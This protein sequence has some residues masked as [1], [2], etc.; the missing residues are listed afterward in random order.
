MMLFT[1][2]SISKFAVFTTAALALT[3]ALHAQSAVLMAANDSIP[4]VAVSANESSSVLPD[5]PSTTAVKSSTSADNALDMLAPG[6]NTAPKYALV[7]QPDQTAQRLGAGG[8]VILGLRAS[9]S[10]TTIAGAV[11]SSGYSHLTDGAPNYGVDRTAYAQ[12]F[13]AAMARGASQNI[14]TDSVLAPVFHTDPRYYVLGDG[15]N[16]AKRAVYA[17]TRVLVTRTDGGRKTVNAPLLVGYL[18]AA[19]LNNA[20]YP[21]INRNTKDTF[22]EYGGSLG[23]AAL[24]YVFNEFQ[25]DLLRAVHLKKK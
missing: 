23:G 2:S 8:K 5:A 21:Q 1:R 16:I 17:A 25:D 10:L 7:I 18:G 20:Y 6:G 24:S 22:F 14:F 12:R 3:G 19:G 4:V 15:N 9:A 13:G 11:I